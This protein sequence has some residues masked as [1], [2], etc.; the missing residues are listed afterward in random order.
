MESEIEIDRPD[1]RKHRADV[2]PLSIF[3]RD[4]E[5]VLKCHDIFLGWAIRLDFGWRV[6]ENT[7]AEAEFAEVVADGLGEHEAMCQLGD[8]AIAYAKMQ[9]AA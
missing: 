4:S 7:G 2:G 6:L 1:L 8:I 3:F 5:W 9:E